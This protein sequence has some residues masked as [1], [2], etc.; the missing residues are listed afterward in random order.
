[1]F[2]AIIVIM[3]FII[4]NTQFFITTS[5]SQSTHIIMIVSGMS[6]IQLEENQ[7]M[8]YSY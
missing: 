3:I 5:A 2:T 4:T 6:T 7:A 1:M 8:T